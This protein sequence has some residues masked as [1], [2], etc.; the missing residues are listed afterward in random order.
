MLLAT[1]KYLKVCVKSKYVTVTLCAGHHASLLVLSHLFL[2]KVRF[3]LQGDVFHKIK[4]VFDF[5]QFATIELVEET[6]CDE[7][8]VLPHQQAVH[9]NHGHR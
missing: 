2:E 8:D 6:V 5:V 9:A 1:F 3:A 7:L 4:G